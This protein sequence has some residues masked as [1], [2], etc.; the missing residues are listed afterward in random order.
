MA[1]WHAVSGVIVHFD[2]GSQYHSRA[3]RDLLKEHGLICGLSKRGDCYNNAAM[4]SSLLHENWLK[5]QVFEYI[6][7]YYNRQRFTQSLAI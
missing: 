7:V 6:E 3:Y 5:K 4:A 1:T 2:R